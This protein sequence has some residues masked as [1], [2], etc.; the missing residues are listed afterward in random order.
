MRLVN[1][2]DHNDLQITSV[3]I[4]KDNYVWLLSDESQNVLIV[5]PGQALPVIKYIQDHKLSPVAILLTHHHSDHIGGLEELCAE[6]P[7]IQIY[8]PNEV[9]EHTDIRLQN[10]INVVN[11]S[12]N[13]SLL[14]KTVEVIETPG[15]TL[16][17]ICYLIDGVLFSG[18]TL[19]SAGCG[20]IFEGN[21]QQMFNSLR[22]LTNLPEN[23][24]ICPTHEYTV[25]N[26]EFCLTVFPDNKEAYEQLLKVKEYLKEGKP[27]LPTVLSIERLIN[28]FLYTQS[29]HLEEKTFKEVYPL[30]HE[31]VFKWLREKKDVF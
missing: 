13:L 6:Y 5:D 4:L 17:H 25:N 21:A 3:P 12:S 27:S 19:F 24:I 15:H 20:R 11:Q 14:S 9:L 23:T 28:P 26:L 2:T 1:T 8:G 31:N 7:Q 30:T 16:G 18:D 22:K 29:I 10:M